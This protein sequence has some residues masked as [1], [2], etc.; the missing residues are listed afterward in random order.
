MR[1]GSQKGD[2]YSYAIILQEIIQRNGPFGQSSED[3]RGNDRQ[4]I[5]SCNCRKVPFLLMVFCPQGSLDLPHPHRWDH[6]WQILPSTTGRTI[7]GRVLPPQIRSTGGRYASYWNAYLFLDKVNFAFILFLL[8]PR[9]R[10]NVICCNVWKDST[11]YC[12]WINFLSSFDSP[13]SYPFSS[14]QID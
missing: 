7:G 6:R 12:C 4:Q 5:I 2:V 1:T 9:Y 10:T 11:V 13:N 14:K 8:T 3:P